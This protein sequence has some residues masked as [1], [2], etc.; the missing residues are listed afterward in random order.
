MLSLD[1][2]SEM[3][4]LDLKHHLFSAGINNAPGTCS[5]ALLLAT[6]SRDI[7]GTSGGL[8]CPFVHSVSQSPSLIVKA[9]SDI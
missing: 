1:G 2:R 4:S 3:D 5:K 7:L 6:F 9:I 8:H